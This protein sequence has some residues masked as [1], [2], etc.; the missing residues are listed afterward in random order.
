MNTLTT[1]QREAACLLASGLSNAD[2][3]A[4]LKINPATLYRW[5]Q[6]L[7]FSERYSQFVKEQEREANS[8]LC[9]LKG[10]AVERLAKLLEDKSPSI[11]LKV[12][13]IVLGRSSGIKPENQSFLEESQS[14]EVLE[15]NAALV[16]RLRGIARQKAGAVMRNEIS[17]A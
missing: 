12:I 6:R 11:A 2:T 10:K 14:S 13:E 8:R 3:A 1:K 4:Q 9:A 7:D 15:F 5:K 16:Q 17:N